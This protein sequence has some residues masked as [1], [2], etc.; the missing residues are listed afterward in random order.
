VVAEQIVLDEQ[1]R[2]SFVV[3]SPWGAQ[4][5]RLQAH[6]A[7]QVGNALAALAIAGVCG[8]PIDAAAAALAST[9]ISPWRMELHYTPA[10][11]A[12]LNDAY[13]ANPASMAA[14]L[15]ALA[16]LPARRRVAVLGVMAELG[17]RS[18]EEHAAIGA[19]ADQ[20]GLE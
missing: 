16:A 1:L 4:T 10:G 2:P 13:N 9:D 8:V 6:G 20:L 19:L 11:G 7:H 5:L 14:A 15:H 18:R 3:R 12:V 17:P